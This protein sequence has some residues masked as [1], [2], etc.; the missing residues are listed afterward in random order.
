M[1][2]TPTTEEKI[3]AKMEEEIWL[4]FCKKLR[5][6]LKEITDPVAL[7][8][9]NR[10]Y[11]ALTD[12]ISNIILL[13]INIDKKPWEEISKAEVRL[14]TIED[15]IKDAKWMAD[16]RNVANILLEKI[17]SEVSYFDDHADYLSENKIKAM[18]LFV[19]LKNYLN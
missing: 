9:S 17:K 11:N 5:L 14:P 7:N 10:S 15:H 4:K 19:S 8:S 2:P 6:K 12:V 18:G 1:T 3:L 16:P 13:E